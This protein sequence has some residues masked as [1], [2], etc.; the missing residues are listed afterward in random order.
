V[1]LLLACHGGSLLRFLG[2]RRKDLLQPIEIDSVDSLYGE[3][4]KEGNTSFVPPNCPQMAAT[5]AANTFH[6]AS[7]SQVSIFFESQTDVVSHRS[8][9]DDNNELQ[10]PNSK[11]LLPAESRKRKARTKATHQAKPIK[12]PASNPAFVDQS[13]VDSSYSSFADHT[14]SPVA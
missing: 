5:R 3:Q 4:A 12:Q 13:A 6:D 7:Q 9:A 14:R 8:D 1:S 2:S 11:L 10:T